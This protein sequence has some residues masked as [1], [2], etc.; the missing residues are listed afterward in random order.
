MPRSFIIICALGLLIS[1]CGHKGPVL[2]LGEKLPVAPNE[3]AALQRGHAYLLSWDIPQINQDGSTLDNLIG[4]DILRMDFDSATPCAT[5]RDTSRQVGY[6]DLEYL[7]DASRTGDRFFVMDRGVES[8]R[9]YRYH[10]VAVNNDK[11]RG[12]RATLDVSAVEPPAPPGDLK[13]TG[14]D[15]LVRLDWSSTV[16]PL[17]EGATLTGYL[18]FRTEA[19]T[20]FPLQPLTPKPSLD[21][22]Y[23]D[24]GVA[25]DIL[26]RYA[27]RSVV[28]QHGQQVESVLSE[29]V[30]ITPRA[31]Q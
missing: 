19:D 12:E 14:L 15:R 17:P 31:G 24:L 11:R 1:A 16:E 29:P 2:P 5:C 9:A 25:N 26:L 28:L 10:V 22:R 21:T 3:L 27:V 13:A 18:V 30:S 4:F 7:Q 23:E 8:Q 6:V 20:P